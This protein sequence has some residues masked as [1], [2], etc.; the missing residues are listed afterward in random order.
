MK[1]IHM[2]IK[3]PQIVCGVQQ[4]VHQGDALKSIKPNK[5]IEHTQLCMHCS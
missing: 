2:W 1:T 3:E 5:A 4:T